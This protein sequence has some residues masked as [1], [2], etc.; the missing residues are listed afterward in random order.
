MD[1][2]TIWQRLFF[3]SDFKILN[4]HRRFTR[5]GAALVALVDS[6]ATHIE[7]NGKSGLG[8]P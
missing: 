3:E 1:I 8:H 6:L 5:D 2:L 4:G 7:R